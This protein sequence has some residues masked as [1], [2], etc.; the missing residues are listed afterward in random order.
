MIPPPQEKKKKQLTSR[1]CL[2]PELGKLDRLL[3]VEGSGDSSDQC[4][5]KV[6]E[7]KIVKN[8]Q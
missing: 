7:K 2:P 3:S 6:K 1:G 4:L 5:G 8:L